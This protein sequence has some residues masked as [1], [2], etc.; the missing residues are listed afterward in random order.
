MQ[1]VLT[2]TSTEYSSSVPSEAIQTSKK[3]E[4][5]IATLMGSAYLSAGEV[6]ILS[7]RKIS[8]LGRGLSSNEIM[9]YLYIK[10]Y[11]H[12]GK[13]KSLSH[14]E[15]CDY[16]GISPRDIYH[17]L[18]SLNKVGLIGIKGN[19][20][21]HSKTITLRHYSLRPSGRFLSL[22]R[23]FFH[24]GNEDYESFKSL[25][26]GAKSMLIYVLSKEK[27]RKNEYGEVVPKSYG[28]SIEVSVPDI[29]NSLGVQRDTVILY[30]REIN[31]K[32][33]DF[34]NVVKALYGTLN[35]RRLAVMQDKRIKYGG[36]ISNA[37]RRSFSTVEN[38]AFGFWRLFD[39]WLTCH[40]YNKAPVSLRDAS[41]G[42]GKIFLSLSSDP[43]QRE[44]KIRSGLFNSVIRLLKEGVGLSAIYKDTVR[45]ISSVGGL[46][47]S[48]PYYLYVGLSPTYQQKIPQSG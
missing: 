45:L 35:D 17:V 34:F 4:D 31:E 23:T 48:L 47:E 12:D 30:I 43:E 42:D 10:L 40:G 16:T 44:V 14:G 13:L 9:V 37:A 32:F 46:S 39:Q 36:I 22:N 29:V 5:I 2:P 6:K 15:L 21:C 25:S 27:F 26:A 41:K 38:K 19:P 20:R 28:N 18:K 11:S 1:D 3:N 33:H 8:S 7:S 24:R